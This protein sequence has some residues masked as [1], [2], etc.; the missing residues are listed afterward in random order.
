MS[1][2][3][4]LI[5]YDAV[6]DGTADTHWLWHGLLA[7][8]KVTLFTSLWKSGKTTLLA[9]YLAHRRAG[10]EFLGLA[11]APGGSLVVS[12]EPRDLWPERRRRLGL[13]SEL[14][15]LTRPFAG[16]PTLADFRGLHEQILELRRDRPLD[17][18]VFDSLAPFL[19]ARTE[20]DAGAMGDALGPF[21]AL[22][23]AGLAVWL[24]HHP[25]KG[26][27]ALGQAA[28]GSGALL[29][30]VDIVVE[31]RHPAGDPFTRRRKLY[32]WSRYDATPRQLMI[33]LSP[34]GTR[35]ERLADAPDEF[36]AHWDVLSVL[37][38]SADGALTRRQI[39]AAW[40]ADVA[41]PHEAT[42]W[43]WLDRAVEL[44][45]AVRVG[46]GTKAEPYGYGLRR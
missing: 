40:P 1:P 26:E 42:L 9:H 21:L 32:G 28:R 7:P 12:E 3:T 22:A 4:Q 24:L 5:S 29:A 43:R 45:L 46:P 17:L 34:D 31:M 11:V 13:G 44:G 33:E 15:V 27:P 6:A 19:P 30:A 36:H 2:L 37:F 14:G 16:R 8:G 41:R 25:A 10:G 18:V 38:E 35:Y 20:N 23:D 39:R